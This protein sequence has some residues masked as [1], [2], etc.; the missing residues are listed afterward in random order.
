MLNRTCHVVP[1][2]VFALFAV[3]GSTGMAFAQSTAATLN[4]TVTDS[5]GAII[6]DAQVKIT[7]QATRQAVETRTSGDG[8]YSM[9]GLASGTYD[10]T[11]SKTG[12]SSLTQKDIFLGPTVVR[13]VNSVLTV[14]Q[15]S[16]Q[17][18]V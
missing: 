5:A 15:V 1:G 13:T 14:G 16:Q 18:T 7:N 9:P 8:T 6:P 11:V 12:F 4:G 17:V 10:V 3:L 2:F